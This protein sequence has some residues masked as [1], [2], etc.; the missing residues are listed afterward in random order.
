MKKFYASAMALTACLSMAAQLLPNEG[1]EGEWEESCPWNTVSGTSLSMTDALQYME[2]AQETGVTVDPI[3]QP[4]GWIISNVLGVVQ[5]VG[6]NFAALGTTI[7]GFKAEGCNSATAVKLMNNPNPFMATQIV[8]AYISLGTSWATNSLDWTTFAPCNKDG[9]VFGGLEFTGRPDLLTFDYKLEAPVAAE[10]EEA[11]E[12]Q[13]GTV[14][15]YAWKGSWSQADVPGNNTMGSGIV[16]TTMVD[17]DRNILGME[18]AE[19]GEVTHSDDAEL[20]AKSLKYIEEFTSDWKSYELPVEYLTKSTP[21]KINVVLSANDYFDSENIVNG[22]SLTVDNVKFV[23]YSRLKS[24]KIDDVDVPGFESDKY[25]YDMTDTELPSL[26]SFVA[27]HMANLPSAKVEIALDQ[28]AATATVKVSNLNE[29]GLD[30][31]GQATH[32]YVI[33]FKAPA[34]EVLPTYAG[35]YEGE[36]S[37]S[38]GDEPAVVPGTVI[39][40]PDADN[41]AKCTFKL[42][43]FSLGEDATLGDIVVPDVDVTAT[44]DGG[45]NFVG[46]VKGLKLNMNGLEIVANVTLNGTIDNAGKAVMNIP[47]IWVMDPANDPDGEAGVPIDVKFNGQLKTN[48]LN[49]VEAAADGK[50]EYYN[51]NGVR[52]SADS[53]TPGFYIKR[54]GGKAQKVYVK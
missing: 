44:A 9:G 17:R 49:N 3:L 7:V 16:T 22:N 46:A 53:L 26:D 45:F 42:P 5:E 41:A 30:V 12:G 10:G 13:K 21:E 14:L 47:V 18:T 20:I 33:K 27:E 2:D 8:P 38:L 37:I 24:L 32:E 31:D 23:Y 39:I 43:N 11:P 51:L 34:L 29:G 6:D 52:M 1:F 19:G 50:V 35:E 40:T 25:E 48:A 54:Q 4:K 28:A 36:V 15:V